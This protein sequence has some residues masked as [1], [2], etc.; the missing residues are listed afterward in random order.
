MDDDYQRAAGQGSASVFR[1]AIGNCPANRLFPRPLFGLIAFCLLWSAGATAAD[2]PRYLFF[3]IAPGAGWNQN[4]PETF[5]RA[6]FDSVTQTLRARENPRLRVGLS[7]VF[8]TLETP[9]NV[10]AKSLRQL[11][12]S[13][14]ETGVPVLVALDGQNWW[15]S[16]PDLWN[17]WDT[18]RPGFNPS[19][20]FNVEWTGWSPAQAVKLGWRNWG[21]QLRVAPAPNLASPRVVEEH[22][23]GLRLLVPILVEWQRR[24]PAERKWLFGGVK[25]GW[26]AGSGYNAFYYPDGNR[27]LEQWPDD[28]SH[29]PTNGLALAKGLASGASQLGYAGVKTMGFKERGELARGDLARVTEQYLERLCRL[30]HEVGLPR[31]SVFTHQGG[32]YSPWDQHLPF[33]PAFNRWSSPGWSFYGVGPHE[34]GPLDQEMQAAGQERWAAAE[35][36]W[37]APDAAGWEDHFRRTLSFRDCRFI[38]VYN[39]NQGMFEKEMAGLEAVRK[40][41][42]T[43]RE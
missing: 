43:W 29:D 8:S 17:W 21:R 24:L 23:K 33:W 11:L 13:S 25:L 7:F 30:A 38:C 20:V 37:G 9:T 1:S 32:N 10:L 4:R 14:E 16:R 18:N 31:E 26:K 34:S 40:L 19:N 36:W 28:P 12:A 35:W 2:S 22:L 3:N 5:S 41:V 6:M 39:W 42:L 27:Y 15:Q